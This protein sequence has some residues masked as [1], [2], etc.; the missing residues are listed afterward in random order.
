MIMLTKLQLSLRP[1]SWLLALLIITS[2]LPAKAQEEPFVFERAE[3]GSGYIMK[4]RPYETYEG[5][6]DVPPVRESDG[7]PIVSVEGFDY[8]ERLLG[9]QFWEGSQVKKIGS[10]NG[11]TGI[12]FVSGIPNTVETIG[13]YAFY[14]C[15]RLH[16]ISLN[17]GLKYIGIACFEGCTSLKSIKLPGSL[18]VLR[19]NAFRI[20]TALETVEFA[21]DL[22]FYTDEG[23]YYS[24]GFYNN[25]FDGCESLHTVILP[26]SASKGLIIPPSTFSWCPNLKSIE[27]PANTRTIGQMAFYRSGIENL[28]LTAVTSDKIYVEGYYSFAGCE[29]LK[30]IKANGNFQFDR[31]SLYTFQDCKALKS[32]TINGSG[33]D[34]IEIT[35]DAFRWCDN[36][37]TV[38]VYRLKGTGERNEMDS[39]FVGCKSLQKFTSTCSP[40]LRKIGYSCF[41]GCESLTEVPIPE[42]AF[43]VSET[44]FRGCAA[45]RSLDLAN[46][47]SIG[48]KAFTGCSSLA[49]ISFKPSSDILP[50][51]ENEDA[52]DEWHFANTLIEVPDDKYR[53]FTTDAFWSKF[54][55]YKHPSML[56]YTEVTGGYSVGKSPYA[57]NEDFIGMLEIPGQYN[58]SDVVS[59]A[60]STFQDLTG[61]TGVTLPEKLTSI[62]NN[63]FAGCTNI[64]T[65]INKRPLPLNGVNCPDNAFD[66]E[67]YSK[68]Y[69]YVPFGSLDAYKS[70]TPWSYFTDRIKQ[71]LGERILVA[72][73]PS[74]ESGEF[75]YPFAL[76]LSNLNDVGTIYYYIVGE[77]DDASAVHTV[78]TYSTPITIDSSCKVV[79]YV[80]DDTSC[81]E[82]VTFEYAYIAPE[83]EPSHIYDISTIPQGTVNVDFTTLSGY[84]TLNNVVIDNVYYSI[85]DIKSGYNQYGGLVLNRTSSIEDVAQFNRDVED[86]PGVYSDFNGIAVKVK[87]TGSISFNAFF[88]Y[89]NVRPTLLLG[90]GTPVFVDELDGLKYEFSTP[91]DKYLYIFASP[92][93]SDTPA[94]M[95]SIDPAENSVVIPGMTIEITDTYAGTENGLDKVLTANAGENYRINTNLFGHYFDGTYL[96]ASTMG[97]SGS[98][99]NTFNEDKKSEPGSDNDADFNQEDWVAISG[100]TSD[101][102]GKEIESGNIATV[103]SNS[104]YPIISLP[105]GIVSTKDN[106]VSNNTFSVANFNIYADNDE[107]RNIW[108][109]APQPA[110]YCSL[111]G[112]MSTEDINA[113]EHYFVLQSAQQVAAP[114]TMNVYYDPAT[115]NLSDS[116]WYSFTGIVS[117]D[118]D[119]LKFTALA[120]KDIPAG[121][122]DVDAGNARIFASNGNINVVADAQTSIIIYSANGLHVASLEASNAS[123]AVTPGFYIV[124]VGNQATK[125]AVK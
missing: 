2:V 3:D 14:G 114:L 92:A 84:E 75:N 45:L 118:G 69:L 19:E 112:Y 32:V 93:K 28:D 27:F 33:D 83:P 30:S 22:D 122:E 102:E 25:V 60:E 62:G 20:C 124:K 100:L 55:R 101:F 59:I 44:A 48:T 90:D 38:D 17:E 51:V 10:F 50:T 68:G 79:A 52:F 77:D 99:K 113:E 18:K 74:R 96:Y 46:V 85:T 82:P 15:T 37:E 53:S 87:G 67:T 80:S 21:E 36:L 24:Y 9:V 31:T 26:K 81:S 54:S 65:I 42:Q 103:V 108:L 107:V 115:L 109:V 1:A 89:G 61:L 72:P 40:E 76:A 91:T 23:G 71:G 121:I 111:I 43:V 58:S 94:S 123:V 7:I 63:A 13:D 16:D 41:D 8:Q 66:N 78:N 86:R 106:S 104:E 5:V 119:A 34:Y 116:G 110:E 49:S 95:P 64:N 39:V 105:E 125:L 97:N 98:S 35:P 56:A 11:C 117:K 47:T 70:Y 12:E 120:K 88:R 73:T 57:L 4:P 6:L 29:N